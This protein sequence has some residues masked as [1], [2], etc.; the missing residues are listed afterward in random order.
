MRIFGG[1]PMKLVEPNYFTDAV[2]GE[3]V[4][5]YRDTL[6]RLW[7]AASPWALFRVKVRRK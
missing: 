5:I 7:M 3:S 4:G 1:R 2:S 6:G